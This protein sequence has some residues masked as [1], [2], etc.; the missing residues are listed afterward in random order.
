MTRNTQQWRAVLLAVLMLGSVV[1]LST[2][3]LAT[4]VT[5]TTLTSSKD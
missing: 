1:A 4:K 5:K 2:P 3:R